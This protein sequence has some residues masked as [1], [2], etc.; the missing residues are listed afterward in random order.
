MLPVANPCRRGKPA[1][2]VGP[3]GHVNTAGVLSC[4]SRFYPLKA[5][6]SHATGQQSAEKMASECTRLYSV[7]FPLRE[8]LA[9]PSTTTPATAQSMN[10]ASMVEVTS[11][12][13]PPEAAQKL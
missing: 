13:A 11:P 9:G 6:L 5:H 7:C 2:G 10:N 4:S 1:S 3:S 12:P 8:R